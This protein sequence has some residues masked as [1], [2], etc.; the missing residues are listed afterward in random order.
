MAGGCR[1]SQVEIPGKFSPFIPL[2]MPAHAG[3]PIT[4]LTAPTG[5]TRLGS[6]C[7]ST[8]A[9]CRPPVCRGS[10]ALRFA[11]LG[12]KRCG[13]EERTLANIEWIDVVQE[14]PPV[15]RRLLL[16]VSA[17]TAGRRPM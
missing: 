3:K 11:Q 2:P 12:V 10:A 15:K 9:K 14:A 1:I 5:A 8:D 6:N 7:G 17:A 4:T 13:F 16:I